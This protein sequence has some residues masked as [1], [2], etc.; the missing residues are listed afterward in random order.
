MT[1]SAIRKTSLL[2]ALGLA[3][4]AL[5]CTRPTYPSELPDA[6]ELGS[7]RG[8]RIARVITHLH[9]PYSNDA[10]DKVGLT[11][12]VP[13]V[14]CLTHLREA[15]CKNRI[16]VALATDHPAHMA[17]YEFASLLL[18]ASGDELLVD[19]AANTYANRLAGCANG[20]RPYLTVGIEGRLL[21]MGMVK[22]LSG[23]AAQREEAYNAETQALRDDLVNTSEAVV[24]VPHTESRTVSTIQTV[25]PHGIEI[26]NVHANLDPKIR[27]KDL[28]L[29]PFE[30]MSKILGYL[31]DPYKSLNADF[32]FMKF[33]ETPAIYFTRW[34][35]L[36]HG[37]LKLTGV[38]GSDSHE[39]IFPQK[40]A[41]GERLES[42]R[43]LTRFMS[44][45]VVVGAATVPEVKQALRTGR[46]W[47]VFE[48]F[49]SPVGLDF[50]AVTGGTTYGMGET[51]T[52]GANSATFTVTTPTLHTSSPG[53]G[54]GVD[55]EVRTELKRVLANG[56]DEV[57]ARSSGFG[58]GG[59]IS[60]TTS[61]AGAYRVE[62]F[63]RPRQLA[64]FIEA[65]DQAER[66]FRWI[67]S[68]HVYLA[69]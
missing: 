61:T 35:E 25:N 4:F 68:N 11:D 28:G 18:Q 30:H 12:G 47:L 3:S 40:A 51:G 56:A 46:S 8:Q 58:V 52:L 62:I 63:I 16:D 7:P 39:N 65:P 5:G 29:P 60:Y 20:F 13:S 6:A 21:A 2:A 10:C 43:R 45:H 49:G 22:H 50:Y 24:M 36:I 14:E 41:D 54:M 9:T 48:G 33:V 42:H 27:K 34:N 66:E 19:G 32:L 17:A 38:G 15:L 26:Y 1:V 37:G 55:P 44:N 57:V 69:P 67:V 23:T 59:N 53:A 64:K 31:F